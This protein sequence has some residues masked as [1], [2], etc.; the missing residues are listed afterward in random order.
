[1]SDDGKGGGSNG[2]GAL[3]RMIEAGFS[4]VREDLRIVHTAQ[5]EVGKEVGALGSRLGNLEQ[6]CAERR[7]HCSDEFRRIGGQALHAE[8]TGRIHL[9]EDK[10]RWRTLSVVGAVIVALMGIVGTVAGLQ[11]CKARAAAPAV[12]AARR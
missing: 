12:D 11:N 10:T 1:M 5:L 4:D 3:T 9:T 7:R 6:R 2:L 8:D